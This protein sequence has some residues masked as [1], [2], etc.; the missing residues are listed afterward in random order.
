VTVSG[1]VTYRARIALAPGAVIRVRLEESARH[2]TA[3]I[4]LA[5]S[6]TVTQGEQV[7]IPF[8]LDADLSAVEHA[9][10]SL[11]ATI[12]VDGRLRFASTTHTVVPVDRTEEIE[13]VV[14]LAQA[15]AP[16]LGGTEWTVVELDGVTLELAEG[17]RAPHLVFDLEEAQ[18]TGSGGVN[19]ITGT[20]ALSES[21]LRFGSLATT[22]MA[23]PEDAMAR[24]RA[25]LD[26]L[27]RVTSYAL[28]GRALRFLADDDAVVVARL[29]C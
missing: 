2:D 7:P 24:E 10:R 3:A 23:G 22:L 11:R 27:A 4:V 20:F 14:E 21:E 25:L 16:S 17:Q 29:A 1:H 18:V 8:R 9:A 5:E 26:A 13:L 12:E 28:E 15:T 6:E 19:R